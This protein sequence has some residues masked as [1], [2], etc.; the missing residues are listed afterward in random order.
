MHTYSLSTHIAAPQQVA[1][2]V[3]TD[4]ELYSRWVGYPQWIERSGW[5]KGPRVVVEVE[6]S[7]HRNGVGAIRVFHTG[8]VRTIEEITAFDPPNRMAY[9]VLKAPLP[10][11]NCRSELVL[12]GSDDGQSC[13]LHW[14]S[15]FEPTIPFAGSTVRLVLARAV[16]SMAAGIAEE[17]RNRAQSA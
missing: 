12:V 4:H 6:G 11:R 1:W 2:E 16:S 14:D 5:G 17:A 7:P 8:P 9:R 10:T 3:M 15:W 13:D